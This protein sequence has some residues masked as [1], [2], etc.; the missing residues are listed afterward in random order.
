[1]PAQAFHANGGEVVGVGKTTDTCRFAKD[2]ADM[3]ESQ[4]G[5]AIML[6][7]NGGVVCNLHPDVPSEEVGGSVCSQIDPKIARHP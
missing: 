3:T 7:K 5:I 1:M 6:D 2:R 4:R